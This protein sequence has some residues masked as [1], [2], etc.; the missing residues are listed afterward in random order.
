MVKYKSNIK[1]VISEWNNKNPKLRKKTLSS[2]AKELGVSTSL[3]SQFN[4][5]IQF[6]KHAIVIFN[7]KD[8]KIQINN[9]K[10]YSQLDIPIIKKLAKIIE[11]L[12]CDIYDIIKA[13]K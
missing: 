8:K 4:N 13:D 2:L 9:F 12:E 10:L 6:Q 3:L 11:L 1:Q 7:C 5:S